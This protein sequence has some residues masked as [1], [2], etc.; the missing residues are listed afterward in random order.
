MLPACP[1]QCAGSTPTPTA[2][3]VCAPP[4]L[5]DSTLRF[6]LLTQLTSAHTLVPGLFTPT[7][8]HALQLAM[9]ACA[10]CMSLLPP[11]PVL[12]PIFSFTDTTL[13]VAQ[14]AHP[15][16]LRP[17]RLHELGPGQHSQ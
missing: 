7:R 2:V 13:L 3:H 6:I 8:C 10:S 14:R 12:Y 9:P 1:W 15:R 5:T 16:L 4:Y 17:V 11:R